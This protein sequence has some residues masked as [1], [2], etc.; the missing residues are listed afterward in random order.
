MLLE[1]Q[2]RG[3]QHAGN[4]LLEP[5]HCRS[6]DNAG[7]TCDG[8]DVATNAHM[9]LEHLYKV[10]YGRL[11]AGLIRLTHDAQLAPTAHSSF[12]EIAKKIPVISLPFFL[13]S[14]SIFFAEP[15]GVR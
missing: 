15:F 4:L 3:E 2:P 7:L 13:S 11:L 10:H 5:S 6:E 14:F 1:R 12:G 8:G 9:Q